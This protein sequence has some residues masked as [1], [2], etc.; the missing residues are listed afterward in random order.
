MFDL[1]KASGDILSGFG[2]ENVVFTPIITIWR[3]N[4][5]CVLYSKQVDDIIWITFDCDGKIELCLY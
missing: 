1:S 2:I 4:N 3:G 5:N